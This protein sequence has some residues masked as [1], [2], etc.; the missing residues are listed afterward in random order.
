M[1]IDSRRYE[2]GEP[3]KGWPISDGPLASTRKRAGRGKSLKGGSGKE[4]SPIRLS[5]Q[6]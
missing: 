6:G 1:Y 4:S 5:R 2:V 3:V